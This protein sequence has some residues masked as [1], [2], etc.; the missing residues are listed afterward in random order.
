ML[1]P[2]PSPGLELDPAV[3][4]VSVLPLALTSHDSGG[5][6]PGLHP[7]FGLDPLVLLVVLVLTFLAVAFL[8]FFPE[9][10]G[11]QAHGGILN[12]GVLDSTW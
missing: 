1:P 5:M 7:V 8:A 6:P 9:D 10:R 2:V 4:V 12:M 11:R 3:P